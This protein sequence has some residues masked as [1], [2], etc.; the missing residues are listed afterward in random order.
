M[1]SLFV[2]INYRNLKLGG[3]QVRHLWAMN[4]E[5]LPGFQS[6]VLHLCYANEQS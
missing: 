4:T 1:L 6:A 2:R 5:R 3:G